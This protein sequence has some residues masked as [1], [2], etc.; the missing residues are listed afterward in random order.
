MLEQVHGVSFQAYMHEL[1]WQRG[2]TQLPT[3]VCVLLQGLQLALSVGLGL[4]PGN[5]LPVCRNMLLL[6]SVSMVH[7]LKN[8]SQGSA[9]IEGTP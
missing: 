8:F 2:L 7:G 1:Y 3:T 6:W 5:S 9:L 4:P